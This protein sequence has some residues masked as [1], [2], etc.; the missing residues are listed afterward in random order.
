MALMRKVRRVEF[1]PVEASGVYVPLVD[2]AR[3][4]ARGLFMIGEAGGEGWS[5]KF[6]WY[7]VQTRPRIEREM[8]ERL[9]TEGFTVFTPIEVITSKVRNGRGKQR[10]KAQYKRVERAYFPGY[11]F[12]QVQMNGRLWSAL[13]AED[14]IVGIVSSSLDGMPAVLPDREID[15]FLN[16]GPIKI[17]RPKPFAAGDTVRIVEGP[18]QSFEAVIHKVDKR[19]R[20]TVLLNL[21][22]Q[23]VD[24]VLEFE[25]VERVAGRLSPRASLA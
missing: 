16:K 9:R 4:G 10:G 22:G 14:G 8:V 12:L 5:G 25:Q 19:D 2:T 21:F 6:G 24:A 20:I 15:Q 3:K 7:A 18:F 11:I 1:D 17:D 23:P 13:R